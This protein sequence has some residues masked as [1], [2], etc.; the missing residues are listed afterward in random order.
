MATNTTTK[1]PIQIMDWQSKLAQGNKDAVTRTVQDNETV[2]KQL[3]DLTAGDSKYIGVARQNAANAASRQG[4]MTSSMAAGNAERAAIEA[5]LPIAQ[6]DASTYAKT[7]ADNMAAQN[8]D[9]LADQAAHAQ[10][11]GQEVGI[12]ANLDEAERGRTFTTQEREAA[13]GWQGGQNQLQ[14]EHEKNMAATDQA[15]RAA[16]AAL[17]RSFNGS[18]ADKQYAQQ[19][20]EMFNQAMVQQ[21]NNLSQ[22]L[23]A[24][25]S[26]PNL[27]AQQQ[28]QAA[29]N[30]R[31]V[32]QSLMNS[33]AATMSGGVPKIFWQPYQQTTGATQTGT[34]APASPSP[35][36]PAPTSPAGGGGG[37]VGY[38]GARPKSSLM[39]VGLR[40]MAQ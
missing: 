6:Q 9:A 21:N 1:N 20:F 18:Q 28:A 3:T 8:A 30:A 17:D 27:N 7:A 19:R 39:G 38:S 5:A 29:A 33:Y 11:T 36:A 32:H 13:Q 14:R 25:Y 16:Q 34:R 10:L 35:V 2:N 26:N 15:F 40:Q 23:A 12:R 37:S 24:I 4:M 22:T 31:A